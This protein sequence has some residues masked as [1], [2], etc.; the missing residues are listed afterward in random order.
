MLIGAVDA[1]C[2]PAR[3]PM[4]IIHLFFERELFVRTIWLNF[5]EDAAETQ[6]QFTGLSPPPVHMVEPRTVLDV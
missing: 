1:D 2:G 4:A 3:A 6:W 5:V